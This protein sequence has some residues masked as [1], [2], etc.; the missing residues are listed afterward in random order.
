MLNRINKYET[1]FDNLT[2]LLNELDITITKLEDTKKDI[3]SLNTYYG[4]KKWHQDRNNIDKYKNI[5]AGI[6]SEDGIWNTL[7]KLNEEVDRLNNLK[8]YLY[9]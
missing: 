5:K 8:E 6:L 7:D 2:N 3:K 1:I 4:S 9:K